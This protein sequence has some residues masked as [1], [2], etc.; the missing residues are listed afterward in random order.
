[1]EPSLRHLLA[2]CMTTAVACSALTS[3]EATEDTPP[4][5]P[6][7][8]SLGLPH[9]VATNSGQ[10]HGGATNT[11]QER[12]Y[13]VEYGRS[14][15]DLLGPDG[16]RAFDTKV[17]SLAATEHAALALIQRPAERPVLYRLLPEGKPEPIATDVVGIPLA[18]TFGS[19]A[20]WAERAPGQS[21]ATIRAYDTAKGLDVARTTTQLNALV[22]AVDGEGAYFVARGRPWHWDLT[23]GSMLQSVEGPE[24]SPEPTG[25]LVSATSTSGARAWSMADLRTVLEKSPGEFERIQPDS[26]FGLFDRSASYVALAG[27]G[28]YVVRDV[29]TGKD[30]ALG[31]PKGADI[32]S[33]AWGLDGSLMVLAGLYDEPGRVGYFGC[34]IPSGACE[35]LSP[36]RSGGFGPAY[37]ESSARGQLQAESPDWE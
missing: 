23:S 19:V 10:A 17:L 7:W 26:M 36:S 33:F 13:A 15:M 12:T 21:V 27:A 30:V 2:A 6:S 28:G 20:V 9:V 25:D 34:S 37:V 14:S 5:P 32:G 4:A 22:T 3:C 31:L 24:Q 11:G 1:M 8:T 16:E 18:D 35:R 29:A